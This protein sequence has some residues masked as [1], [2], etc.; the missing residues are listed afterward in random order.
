MV[1]VDSR[2]M[3]LLYPSDIELF[4][5]LSDLREELELINEAIIVLERLAVGQLKRRRR[6]PAWLAL[7]KDNRNV[8]VRQVERIET[9]MAKAQVN[10]CPP[11]VL[12]QSGINQR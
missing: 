9:E 11:K 5:T 4:E 12:L 8:D 7:L 2:T 1:R 10:N 6:S 3:G